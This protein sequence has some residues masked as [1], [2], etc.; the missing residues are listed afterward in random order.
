MSIG[1]DD[2]A[3]ATLMDWVCTHELEVVGVGRLHDLDEP[4]DARRL[5][6]GSWMRMDVSINNPKVYAVPV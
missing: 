5:F 1:P 2:W 4:H 6:V 3:Q